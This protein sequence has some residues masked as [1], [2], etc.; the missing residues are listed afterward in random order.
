MMRGQQLKERHREPEAE[1][2]TRQQN[3]PLLR[4]ACRHRPVIGNSR[5][6]WGCD[7]LNIAEKNYILFKKYIYIGHLVFLQ[8][9]TSPSSP[10][11]TQIQT[12]N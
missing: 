5:F 3:F 7:A 2:Q 4:L 9:P 6:L 8:A 10:Q 1:Q 11:C 12:G